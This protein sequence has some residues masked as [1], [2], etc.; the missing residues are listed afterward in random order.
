MEM[1]QCL[2]PT[3]HIPK[4]EPSYFTNKRLKVNLE[5]T[6]KPIRSDQRSIRFPKQQS[7]KIEPSRLF[8]EPIAPV[9]STT[10]P[11]RS[12]AEMKT[13]APARN[14]ATEILVI[15]EPVQEEET[16]IEEE[17]HTSP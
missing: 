12:Q 1:S 17:V 5:Y 8:F 6:I 11:I 15:P 3:Q 16:K 14:L 2:P 9:Q 10:T 13:E 4:D 7:L